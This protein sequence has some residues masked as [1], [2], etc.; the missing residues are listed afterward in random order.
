MADVFLSY[1]RADHPQAEALANA[2]KQ[3]RWSVWWDGDI[4]VGKKFSGEIERELGS[5]SCVVVLW[6]KTSVQSDFVKDEA[7]RA[8]H[9]NCLVPVLIDAVALPL[10]FGQLQTADLSQWRPG[11]ETVELRRLFE[12][13]ESAIP[14]HTRST[15]PAL[16]SLAAP[17]RPSAAM[18]EHAVQELHEG[19]I[20]RDEPIRQ[21]P[22]PFSLGWLRSLV[23]SRG[24]AFW[25]P[26]LIEVIAVAAVLVVTILVI[27]SARSAIASRLKIG[28]TGG[29]VP[30]SPPSSTEDAQQSPGASPGQLQPPGSSDTGARV[31]AARVPSRGSSP[32][33]LALFD[34]DPSPSGPAGAVP[35]DKGFWLSLGP[36]QT[37]EAGRKQRDKI[38]PLQFVSK[39]EVRRSDVDH[40]LY[41]VVGP[42]AAANTPALV[43]KR[44]PEHLIGNPSIT[45]V[46]KP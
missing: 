41:V 14:D 24:S 5:A 18:A 31:A 3:Q 45:Y 25:P 42:Y 9:R 8:M 22:T 34:S 23:T 40:L 21:N 6:S 4:E 12:A 46:R 36:Y 26:T 17:T 30:G 44:L 28:E 13:I 19:P 20:Q 35:N 1:A 11:E 32:E 2:L 39:A 15:E 7:S 43:A 16:Q 33:S 29:A 38:L 27:P 10:G 37:L